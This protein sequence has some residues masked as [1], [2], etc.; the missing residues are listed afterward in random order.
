MVE[1]RTDLPT[2][3]TVCFRDGGFYVIKTYDDETWEQL[4]EHAMLNAGLLR[5]EDARGNVLWSLP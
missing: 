2:R 1:R 5:M 3:D 4:A